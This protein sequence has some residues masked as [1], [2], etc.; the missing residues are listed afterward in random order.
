MKILMTGSTGFIGSHMIERLRVDHEVVE[1]TA[2]LRD[3]AEVK[4]QVQL[5]NPELI[6]HLAART[7]VEKSFYEQTTFSDINYTGTVNLIECAKDLPNLKN[8]IF[9]STMEVYGYQNLENYVSKSEDDGIGSS[10]MLA[11]N[12]KTIPAPNAPYAVAKYGCEKYLEYAGRSFNFPYTII[13]QTNSYGR[14]DNNFFVVEQMI[15]QMLT[16]ETAEFGYF[17]PYRNFI[18]ITDLLDAWE[19]VINNPVQSAGEIFCL[20]PNNAIRID[21]LAEVIA[22]KIGFTGE[23]EWNRKRD[24]PGEIMLLNSSNHKITNALGWSPKVD[25]DTGLDRTITTW[26]EILANNLPFVDDSVI[27]Q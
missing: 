18:Y 23:I 27:N 15:Y 10:V 13:R 14:R 11:F 5:S 3:H 20:G 21:R 7:E 24:R 9:A 12:E 19:A 1:L 8:F 4:I 25:L 22:D 16:K 6:V 2:D 17:E 26:R